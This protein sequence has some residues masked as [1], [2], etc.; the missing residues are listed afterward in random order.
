MEL[1]KEIL[2]FLDLLY[3]KCL[4]FDA[5]FLKDM[6][7]DLDEPEDEDLREHIRLRLIKRKVVSKFVKSRSSPMIESVEEIE[8]LLAE[9][10]QIADEDLLNEFL[11]E[12]SLNEI[13]R[14]AER[15]R[16]LISLRVGKPPGK[17]V[18]NYYRQATNCYMFGLYDAVAILSPSI[19]QFSLEEALKEKVLPLFPQETKGYLESLIDRAKKVGIL[20]N[21]H[22]PLA[23]TIRK[24]GNKAVHV[25][26]TD[27][28]T[29][30]KVIKDTGMV[31]SQIYSV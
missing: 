20:K 31:V 2:K 22:L 7:I 27:E 23:H 1:S 30:R 16:K 21:E 17:K 26:S 6:I 18:E 9:F 19:L 12:R 29:A 25:N 14:Y 11:T 24:V 15:L 4:Y 13:P 5:D 3:S 10:S 28:A 8:K